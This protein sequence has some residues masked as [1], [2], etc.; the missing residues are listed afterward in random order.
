MVETIPITEQL[1]EFDKILDDLAN[2]DVVL[3]D[4]DKVFHL[5]CAL[6]KSYERFKDTMLYG[7]EDTIILG[8][9]QAVLRTKELTKFQNLKVWKT[10]WM[11]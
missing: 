5:L 11:P 6:P 2:V 9:V 7:K 10:V 3:E 8:E 1:M 4:E